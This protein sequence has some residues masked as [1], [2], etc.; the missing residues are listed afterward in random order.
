MKNFFYSLLVCFAFFASSAIAEEKSLTIIH[1]ND[2]HSH[3]LGHSPNKDYSPGE[4]GNDQTLGGWA[5]IAAVIRSE[6]EK[7]NN[8]VLLLD[9]GDFLMGTLF[10]LVSREEAIELGLMKEMGYDATTLGNHE[11][12][13]GPD[14]LARVLNAAARKGKIPLILCAN[15][16]FSEEDERDDS[17]KEVFDRGIVRPYAVLVRDGIRIG[18]F[19][20]IGQDAA[21]KA[22]FASPLKF[23]DFRLSARRMVLR[24]KEKEKVDL[25]IGLSHSGLFSDKGRSEDEILAEE[26]PGIDIIVSGHTHTKLPKPIVKESTGT[27]IVQAWAYGR[28]VG[29]LDLA[30][31]DGGVRLKNY[32]AIEV[33]DTIMGDA[34]IDEAIGSY[35]EVI[36]QKVLKELD[37]TFQQTIAET[38]FDLR[39]GARESNLGNMV[40]DALR[41]YLNR[42]E[43]GRSER[44]GVTMQSNGLIRTN[45]LRGKTGLIGVSDLFRVNPLGIGMDGTPGYPLVSSYLYASEIK[46]LLEVPATIVPL[47]GNEYFLHFSG[48][49]VKYNP[50][51]MLF[52]RVTEILIE[53]KNGEFRPLDLSASNKELYR[54]TS[55]LYN[56]SFIKIIGSLTHNI[57][58]ITPKDKNGN[59]LTELAEALVDGDK[60]LPGLQEL[61]DWKAL[62]EYVRSF[63]DTDGDGVPEIPERYRGIE[64]RM[65][66]VPS[67]NPYDLLVGGN[68]LTWIAFGTF[69]IAL[70]LIIYVVIFVV[71]K[72]SRV[73]GFKGSSG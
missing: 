50:Y 70:A 69:I 3:L 25:V 65:V 4:L 71:K 34:K 67:L 15:A 43:D 6:K 68:Y 12:D 7:R 45:I 61:K 10:H 18:L 21:Q 1:T 27:I 38:D 28:H 63:D 17:L 58:N 2:L 19:G 40:A 36:N 26:V 41:W 33:N 9:A 54:V 23:E 11:F 57:L 30:V 14:G 24:L 62:M 55:N 44:V 20:L 64:G 60:E 53:D 46:K 51:R 13:F 29:V 35:I 66:R 49:K 22:P 39:I 32:R 56:A 72:V 47:K 8:P 31:G 52:D 73:R 16:I 59:P 42:L 48:I 37:L 5:R